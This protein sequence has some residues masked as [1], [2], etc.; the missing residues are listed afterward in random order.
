VIGEKFVLHRFPRLPQFVVAEQ[1]RLK[2]VARVPAEQVLPY[3]VR[4]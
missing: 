1:E 3:I 4:E 2:A